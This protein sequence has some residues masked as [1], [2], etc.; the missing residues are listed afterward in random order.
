M[1][2]KILVPLKK[3]DRVEEIVPFIEKMAE[4]GTSVV[5]L[6]HHPVKGL[7]WLQAYSAISQCGIDSALAIRRMVESYSV[8]MRAQLARQKVFN[9]C[10]AL[11]KLRVKVAVEVYTGSLSRTLRSYA[12]NGDNLVLMRPGMA[13]RI[14]SFLQGTASIRGMFRRPFSLS[15]ILQHSGA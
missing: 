6:V 10:E 7:K 8:Q 12:N 14:V 11:N 3:H 13:E 2:S 4:P 15:V 9:A 1:N 5:F